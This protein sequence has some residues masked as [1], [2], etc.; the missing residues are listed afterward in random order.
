MIGLTAQKHNFDL[1]T[2]KGMAEMSLAL[3]KDLNIKETPEDLNELLDIITKEDPGYVMALMQGSHTFRREELLQVHTIMHWSENGFPVFDLT[4]SL[5]AAL[6]LTDP[7]D[8]LAEEIQPPFPTFVI[9]FPG[10]FWKITDSLGTPKPVSYALIHHWQAAKSFEERDIIQTR[11]V[12]RL[13]SKGLTI[14]DITQVWE[15]LPPL[16][17]GKTVAEWLTLEIPDVEENSV[18]EGISETG[19]DKGALMAFRRM[20]INMCLYINENGRGEH[21]AARPTRQKKGKDK[22]KA[23]SEKTPLDIWIL[24][25]EVKLDSNLIASARAWS[26]AQTGDRGSWKVQ[27]RFTVR[28][29]WRRHAHGP[30]KTLRKRIWIKPFWKGEGARLGHLYTMGEDS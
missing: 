14:E 11:V 8:V 1:A 5:A 20:Y 3:K 21:Q 22:G 9:R 26:D 15:I 30:G 18:V 25:R 4:H 23:K 13:V 2:V 29:H 7:G 12:T 10:D 16:P 19:V 27:K 17:V 24:G 28:G 6:L